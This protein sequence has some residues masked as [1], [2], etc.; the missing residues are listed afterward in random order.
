MVEAAAELLDGAG[1]L[2]E[3]LRTPTSADNAAEP[4]VERVDH[5][6]A[7][8]IE[9]EAQSAANG[10]ETA[11]GEIEPSGEDDL[12]AAPPAPVAAE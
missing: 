6:E 10:G 3:P 11:M 7:D 8:A 5:D 1:W 4:D 9:G 12:A 2:P